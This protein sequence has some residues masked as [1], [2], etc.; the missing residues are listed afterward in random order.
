MAT[1]IET[2][3]S[4]ISQ[5]LDVIKEK[6]DYDNNSCAFGHFYLTMNF[7]I[8]DQEAFES[9][10]DGF[11]DNGIDAVYIDRGGD[12][13]LNFLQFKFP[14]TVENIKIMIPDKKD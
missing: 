5:E 10:T 6:Y 2:V 14:T 1:K 9:I 4:K 8:D 3:Y 13:V 12:T 7:D 11:G